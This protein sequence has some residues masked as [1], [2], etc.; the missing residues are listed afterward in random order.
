MKQDTAPTRVT[1]A[2]DPRTDLSPAD[3]LLR[4]L[5]SSLAGQFELFGELGR[6]SGGRI[7]YLAR[8]IASGRLVALQL[9][10]TGTKTVGG[11]DYWFE[12]LRTLDANVPAPD[13]DCPRCRRDPRRNGGSTGPTRLTACGIA[14][15]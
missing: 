8:E 4:T 9:T 5:Q 10:P 15:G 12:I 11:E 7:V 13:S 3:R 2:A 6:G 14:A 1:V